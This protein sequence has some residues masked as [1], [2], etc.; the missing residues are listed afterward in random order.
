MVGYG[1]VL[2]LPNIIVDKMNVN[3]LM[4][5]RMCLEAKME[6]LSVANKKLYD[7]LEGN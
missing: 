4:S 3:L 6:I 7:F 2:E 1:Y 5:E